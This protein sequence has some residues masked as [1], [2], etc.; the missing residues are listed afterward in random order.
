MVPVSLA[1]FTAQILLMNHEPSDDNRNGPVPN[2]RLQIAQKLKLKDPK[3]RAHQI[4]AR[5]IEMAES[6]LPSRLG[7]VYTKVTISCLKCLDKNNADFGDESEFKD[8]D[9]ILV[10]IRF[11]EKVRTFFYFYL[12]CF[13]LGFC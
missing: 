5:F 4:K 8:R 1:P 3:V 13:V 12:S 11:I 7:K 6:Q 9:D 2:S 10:G